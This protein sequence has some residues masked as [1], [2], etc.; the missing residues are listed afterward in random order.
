M[1]RKIIKIDEA[2]CTGC[3]DCIPGCP[4]GA[5]RI[6]DGKA[7]LVKDSF[8]DGLGACLGKCPEGAIRIEER[9]TE[10]YDEERVMAN[11][12]QKGES[13][14]KAHLEH[15]KEH[16]EEEA[17]QTAMSVLER[18]KDGA[19]SPEHHAGGCP[20]SQNKMFVRHDAAQGSQRC[21]EGEMPSE[22]GHWPIQLHLISP[23]A[24]QYLKK[25]LLL[26]A[27][28]VAYTVGAFHSG[29]LRGKSLAIACPKLDE[30]QEIYLEKLTALIDQAEINTLTVMIME[31]PC[32]SGLL[33]L[34]QAAAAKAK[35]KVPIK[36]IQISLQGEVL[37]EKWI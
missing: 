7:K 1:L 6:V 33:R 21:A 3:G 32:C 37:G 29:H 2:K 31:V 16:G 12:I 24:P 20:G 10:S 35:R 17:L 9:E 25:D 4:E 8:C 5:L 19:H 14:V 34:A 26:C 36:C 23:R 11:I 22:L 15:L 28:C 30:G 27:D 13:A 18:G